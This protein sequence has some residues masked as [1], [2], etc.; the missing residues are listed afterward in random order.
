M[1]KSS[2]YGLLWGAWL[3]GCLGYLGYGLSTW[4][5]WIIFVPVAIL[6]GLEK[7]TFKDEE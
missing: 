5:F 3:G 4:E 6:A 7:T 1:K 2:I